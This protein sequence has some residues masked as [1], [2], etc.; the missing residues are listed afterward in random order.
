MIIDYNSHPWIFP[1][2]DNYENG[3]LDYD[4]IERVMSQLLAEI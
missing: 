2:E 1:Q 4:E 3:D